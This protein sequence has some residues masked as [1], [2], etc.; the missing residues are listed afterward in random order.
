[1]NTWEIVGYVILAAFAIG[2]IV[3]IRDI[4]RY[5]RMKTM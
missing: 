5:I 1:M 3:N 2:I 4:R